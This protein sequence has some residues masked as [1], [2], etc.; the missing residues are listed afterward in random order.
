MDELRNAYRQTLIIGAIFILCVFIYAAIVELIKNKFITFKL[1]SSPFEVEILRF[2][3]LGMTLFEFFLGKKDAK[4][5]PLTKRGNWKNFESKRIFFPEGL[6]TDQCG[7]HYIR[8]L[9]IG[10][11]L[12]P[13]SFFNWRELF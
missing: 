2:V 1:L 13:G 11:Y 3:F 4:P 9:R 7:V 10:G 12:W 8:Y 6:Q 5:R